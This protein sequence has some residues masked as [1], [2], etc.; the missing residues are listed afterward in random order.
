MDNQCISPYSFIELIKL[1]NAANGSNLP[2]A[3]YSAAREQQLFNV[4]ISQPLL[5]F[6][7]AGS[8]LLQ[9]ERRI[10]CATGEFIFLGSSPNINMRNVPDDRDYYALLIEFE[11]SDFDCLPTHTSKPIDFIHGTLDLPLAKGLQQFIEWSQFAPQALWAQRRRE[12]LQLLFHLGHTDVARLAG[13]QFVSQQVH[14]MIIKDLS[15]DISAE[16]IAQALAMSESTL[17]RKLA[18]ENTSLQQLKDQARLGYGLHLL[19][20]TE[21]PIIQIAEHCG[22]QS[23]SRFSSR[24]KQ[25][26]GLTPSALRHTRMHEK[27]ECLNA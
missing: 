22:Y 9:T 8:K 5:I 27:G 19:Q 1:A 23:Q 24:F 11:H 26:F 2:F 4:P 20:T 14:K 15:E 21:W 16:G 6:V 12:L 25:R 18:A 13:N 10:L 7:L 3:I 17:R